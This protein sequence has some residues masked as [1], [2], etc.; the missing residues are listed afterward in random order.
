VVAGEE[1]EVIG[2]QRRG[3]PP[4]KKLPR[5]SCHAK[6]AAKESCQRKLPGMNGAKLSSSAVSFTV[7]DFFGR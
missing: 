5:K 3:N 4:Q 1:T 6:K 2:L 7:L